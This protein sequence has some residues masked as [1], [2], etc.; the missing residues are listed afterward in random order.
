MDPQI[1]ILAL[2]V[3]CLGTSQGPVKAIGKTLLHDYHWHNAL[4]KALW[5][6]I[7]GLPSD[8]PQ[9]LRQLLPAKLTRLGFPDIEWD[10]FFAPHSLSKDEAIALMR[11]MASS[12]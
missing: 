5:D 9:I 2:R 8:N 1:E 3:L 12:R 10:E 4:H 11:R 6:A 7:S